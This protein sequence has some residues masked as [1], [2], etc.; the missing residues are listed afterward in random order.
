MGTAWA[1]S[2]SYP[3]EQ[4][5]YVG[6]L[7]T[8]KVNL[9]LRIYS[10]QWHMYAGL[11][12]L[13]P[14]RPVRVRCLSLQSLSRTHVKRYA[15]SATELFKLMLAGGNGTEEDKKA[16]GARVEWGGKVIFGLGGEKKKRRPIL[17]SEDVLDSNNN[18][19]GNDTQGEQSPQYATVT[20]PTSSVPYIAASTDT[21]AV[22]QL[23]WRL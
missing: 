20:V 18:G 5:L 22:L 6:G 7:E 1:V 12:I 19:N 16:F 11:A 15:K 23:S 21:P 8:A 13:N 4:G 2:Q 9:T 17:L 14:N 10:N 3:W